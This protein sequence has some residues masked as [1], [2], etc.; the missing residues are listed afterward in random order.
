M[1][2]DVVVGSSPAK[3]ACNCVVSISHLIS[4]DLGCFTSLSQPKITSPHRRSAH[5]SGDFVFERRQKAFAGFLLDEEKNIQ[6]QNYRGTTR[7]K[8]TEKEGQA[9][10]KREKKEKKLLKLGI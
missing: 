9:P 5:C 2:G 6:L 8:H 3:V 10:R 1:Q 7:E 4:P